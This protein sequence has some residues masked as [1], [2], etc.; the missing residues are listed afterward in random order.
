MNTKEMLMHAMRRNDTL[1]CCGL[2]PDLT[3]MPSEITRKGMR[4]EEKVLAFLEAVTDVTSAYV[5][6]Y[7]VQKAFFDV[8]DG[9]R[10]LLHSTVSYIHE[11]S[12]SIPVIVDAKV[13]DT[14]NTML[15][16]RKNILDELNADG[17][18]VNPY[19]GDEVFAD[20]AGHRE[21]AVVVVVR[22]SNPG[23]I[24][25]QEA[26]LSDGSFLW[27]RVLDLTV[28]KWNYSGNLIPILSSTAGINYTKARKSIPDETPILLAGYGAQGGT[29]SH[30]DQ[31]LNSERQGVFVN[32]SRQLLYPY[33]KGD[34][35]WR[36]KIEQATIKMRD[37][38]NQVRYGNRILLR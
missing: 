34:P 5:C 25:V 22:S 12:P 33:A 27:E 3:K 26:T 30:L 7:K 18:V 31:L 19:L 20:L 4:D 11:T 38:I 1:V 16:Y 28:N 24:C 17:I 23:S 10:Q 36:S 37:S 32:S 2:D 29:L 6:A 21:K 15:A 13:G 9:G 14:E 35:E 8:F